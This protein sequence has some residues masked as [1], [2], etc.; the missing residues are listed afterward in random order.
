MK[1]LIEA[2]NKVGN[3]ENIFIS[4]YIRVLNL[5]SKPIQ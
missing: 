3:V 4:K 5:V 2:V 1:V